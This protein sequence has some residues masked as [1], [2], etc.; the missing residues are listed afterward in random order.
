MSHPVILF[1]GVCNLCNA[2]VRFVVKRDKSEKYRFASLQS[3]HA[4]ELLL[5]N[6]V[7]P[8]SF[9]SIVLFEAGEIFTKSTA[10][11][12]IA[13]NLSGFWPML[14]VF[15][16]LPVFLRDPVYDFIARN[17]YKWFGKKEHCEV[18]APELK[19]RFLG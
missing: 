19:E 9:D 3:D 4:K 6:G 16:A 11:L 14:Y 12:K 15:M 18:P 17:R 5:E 1:D 8:H 10:A 13:Q 7:D 2:S